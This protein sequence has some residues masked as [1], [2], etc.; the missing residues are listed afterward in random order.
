LESVDSEVGIDGFEAVSLLLG[1]FRSNIYR[2][3]SRLRW[4]DIFGEIRGLYNTRWSR[5]KSA[6]HVLE[7][8][9]SR[10]VRVLFQ[11]DTTRWNWRNY[12]EPVFEYAEE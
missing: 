11:K 10:I 7:S 12:V 8:S 4:K 6:E 5:W 3:L 9:A 1:A 2:K